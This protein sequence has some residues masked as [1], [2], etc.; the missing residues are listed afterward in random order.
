[1][2][3]QQNN[4]IIKSQQK[5]KGKNYMKFKIGNKVR[6]VRV[7]HSNKHREKYIGKVCTVESI[8]PNGSNIDE[9]YG[10]ENAGSYIFYADELELVEFIK[11]D[12]KD[13]MVIE[14]RDG[15]RRI[16]LGDKLM[17]YDSWVDIVAFNDNLECKNNKV[18]NIDKVYNSDS[19]ILKDYFKDKSLT[20]I[21][22]RNKKEEEPAKKMTVA[23]IE[24]ELGY[25]V[26]IV[27]ND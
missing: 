21:W 25:K 15:D 20:L 24:K 3:N 17:G 2:T 26:E 23:E 11:S 16:V 18:L 27:S 10:L 4:I 9:H 5:T 19:H 13:G 6:V 12:L 8:N 14:Y 7:T 22:E 1:M